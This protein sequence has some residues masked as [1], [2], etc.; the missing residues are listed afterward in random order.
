M[1]PLMDLKV[2][3]DDF[4]DDYRMGKL[5]VAWAVAGACARTAGAPL[6]RIAILQQTAGSGSAYSGGML[7]IGE[8][9]SMCF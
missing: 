4:V 2:N 8:C 1:A 3:L 6:S 5:F 7:E 9:S